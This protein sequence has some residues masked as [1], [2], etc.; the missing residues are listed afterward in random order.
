MRLVL[1]F[2]VAVLSS[3]ATLTINPPVIYDCTGPFGKATLRW[4]GAAGPVQV[5]VGPSRVVMTGFAGTS[6]S[7]ETGLWVSNGLEFRLVNASGAVEAASVAQV[8]CN[9]GDLAANGIVGSSYFPLDVG[10]MWVYKTDSRFVTSDY[11]TW[12]VTDWKTRGVHMYAEISVVSSANTSFTM[13]LREETGGVIWRFTGTADNPKEE[14]YLNPAAVQ[15]APFRNPLGSF[16]DSAILQ[17]VDP[18]FSRDERVFVRG[19]G[20]ARSRFIIGGG[21]NGGFG[22]SLELIEYHLAS[23]PR[24]NVSSPRVSVSAESTL[25][26]V[27]GKQM[28]NCAIPCYYAACGVGSPVDPPNTYKPCTRTRLEGSAEVDFSGELSLL[29]AAGQAVFKSALIPS[30]AGE[31]LRYIQVPLYSKPNEPLP[32]GTYRLVGRIAQGGAETA[33]SLLTI[34]LR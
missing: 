21:S 26:D 28:T 27:T 19:V 11:V 22:D 23:G 14:V 9:A 3:A 30:P 34:E 4:T 29:N 31:L 6:G 12:R 18:F 1:L 10:N 5:V 17:T 33:T 15:H 8:R 20:L 13:L 24:V 25:L 7:A 2:S 16:P 32:A